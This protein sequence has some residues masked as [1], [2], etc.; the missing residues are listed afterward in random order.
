VQCL[1][2]QDEPAP[3]LGPLPSPHAR[4]QGIFQ[5]LYFGVG[6]GF[7]ALAGGVLMQR[8]GGRA[9]FLQ[10]AGIVA[11]AW[12]ACAAA[13]RAWARAPATA[14]A[15]TLGAGAA[16]RPWGHSARRWLGQLL[17]ARLGGSG[18][19]GA[20]APAGG[21]GAAAP[22]AALYSELKS[23]DSGPDLAHIGPDTV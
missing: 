9:M 18:G 11:A 13:E 3:T 12:A 8:Y 16:P 2:P 4:R 1:A 20:A 21:A 22:R 17:P 7:G 23:K 6:Q 14:G 19:G 5:G 10:T 15:A